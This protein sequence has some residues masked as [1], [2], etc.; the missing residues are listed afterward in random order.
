MKEINDL[1]Y[2]LREDKDTA[3][4]IS[5]EVAQWFRQ[6][7]IAFK[8]QKLPLLKNCRFALADGSEFIEIDAKGNVK[9]I[10]TVRPDWYPDPGEFLRE[11]WLKNK[12]MHDQSIVEFL[13]NFLEMFPDVKDRR[14][15]GNFLLNLELDKLPS[16]MPAYNAKQTVGRVGNRNKLSTQPKVADLNSF[17]MFQT[18]YQNLEG[19]VSANRFPTMQLLTGFDNIAKAPTP[20]KGSVRTWFKAI[21]GELPPNNKKVQAG[22]ADVFCAPIQTS[23]QQIKDYGLEKFY[24]ELSQAIQQAGDLDLNKF[25]YKLPN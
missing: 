16:A 24:A 19:A 23:L 25:E 12:E 5:A 1:H 17:E 2:V 13:R 8:G 3:F 11:Q 14:L 4:S 7:L 22:H 9:P 15:H 6:T 21:T 18:F 10:T 20:L